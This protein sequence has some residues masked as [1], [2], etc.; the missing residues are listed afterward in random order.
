MQH[1]PLFIPWRLLI[2]SPH[3]IV[4]CG[5]GKSS[6]KGPH[7]MTKAML[8]RWEGATLGIAAGRGVAQRD[9]H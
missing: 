4:E 5:K 6:K 1:D 9:V 8:D 7:S 2:L 3:L